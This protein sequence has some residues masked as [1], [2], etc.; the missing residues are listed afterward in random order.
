MK[1]SLK[2]ISERLEKD[3]H[4]IRFKD[5]YSTLRLNRPVFLTD[6]TELLAD[7]LYITSADRLPSNLTYQNG[8]AL[9]LTGNI[10]TDVLNCPA[11]ILVSETADIF[12]VHNYVNG[13]F[14]F[15]DDWQHKLEYISTHYGRMSSFKKCLEASLK[16]FENPVSI[17]DPSYNYLIASLESSQAAF[18]VKKLSDKMKNYINDSPFGRMLAS[19]KDVF[20]ISDPHLQHRMIV[21]NVFYGRDVIYRLS[22]HESTR[23]FRETDYILLDLLAHYISESFEKDYSDSDSGSAVL[24]KLLSSALSSGIINKSSLKLELDKINWSASDQFV[25]AYTQTTYQDLTLDSIPYYCEEI[26]RDYPGV[27]AFSYQGNIAIL[28]NLNLFSGA[29]DL[30]PIQSGAVESQANAAMSQITDAKI[31][32]T[33]KSD[34]AA[35]SME[36]N[37]VSA[38]GGKLTESVNVEISDTNKSDEAAS[39]GSKSAESVKA[40]AEGSKSADSAKADDEPDYIIALS[41]FLSSYNMRV[42]ISNTFDNIYKIRHY[43]RQAQTALDVGS[44]LHP[45]DMI[46]YFHK[47]VLPLLINLASMEFTKDDLVSPVYARIKQHDQQNN[48]EYLKTLREYLNQN[49]NTAQTAS[50]LY[51]HRLTMVY[52]VKRICEIGK[53]DLKKPDE[54]L[55]LALSFMI[56]ES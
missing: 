34:S 49:L 47:C 32:N 53:T 46:S 14:D 24:S 56:D 51:I 3:V 16:V 13:I 8:C 31:Q 30:N 23:A 15:F 54:L 43:F 12:K 19:E 9:I 52:R 22:V 33:A 18:N 4:V 6:E 40:S 20:T 38:D 7:T 36:T 25:I 27:L 42:G 35:D 50:A 39:N 21:R 29:D 26:A 10:N 45:D 28:F 41:E 1:L 17:S 55:H 5:I 2:I 48:T 11:V 44:R 37:Q